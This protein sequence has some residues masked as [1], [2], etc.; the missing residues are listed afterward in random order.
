MILYGAAISIYLTDMALNAF[1]FWYLFQHIGNLKLFPR[2]MILRALHSSSFT[3][4]H[5]EEHYSTELKCALLAYC[6]FIILLY[7]TSYKVIFH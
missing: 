1:T 6:P 5:F 3:V 4:L 7:L 2:E